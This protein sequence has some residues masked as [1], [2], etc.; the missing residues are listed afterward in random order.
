MA[1]VIGADRL[2]DCDLVI[3]RGCTLDAQVSWTDDDGAVPFQSQ[4]V[5]DYS[6]AFFVSGDDEVSIMSVDY[7]E[8]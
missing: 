6:V 2:L 1:E 7:N 8:D 3:V 5:Q 4:F